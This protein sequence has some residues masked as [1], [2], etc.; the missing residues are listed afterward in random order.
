MK[1]FPY[2]V[3][4]VIRAFPE[5]DD[6]VVYGIPDS[7]YGELPCADVVF[8]NCAEPETAINRLKEFCYRQLSPYKT[9]KV[10][11][12]VKVLATTLSGKTRR[13]KSV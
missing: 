1:I 10:F 3:E 5:V 13:G 9:P 11:N 2:E 7:Q 12:P 8:R 4:A 6:V